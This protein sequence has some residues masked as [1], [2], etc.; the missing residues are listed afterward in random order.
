[1]MSSAQLRLMS[2]LKSIRQEPP[3]VADSLF[4]WVVVGLQSFWVSEASCSFFPFVRMFFLF[5]CGVSVWVFGVSAG[6][7]L[8]LVT[9]SF[10][11]FWGFLMWRFSHMIDFVAWLLV[12]V[13]DSV[14][15]VGFRILLHSGVGVFGG[16]GGGGGKRRKEED[17][18]FWR[19]DLC[20]LRCF[21]FSEI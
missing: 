14:A 21:F 13:M 20:L 7:S 4:L 11:L 19:T 3:E 8:V 15:V 1:M 12:C 10:F 2:D 17:L 6:F 16:L 18:W 9:G 5:L